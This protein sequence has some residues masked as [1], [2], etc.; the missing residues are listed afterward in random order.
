LVFSWNVSLNKSGKKN[1]FLNVQIDN[2]ISNALKLKIHIAK[3]GRSRAALSGVRLKVNSQYFGI[4][5]SDTRDQHVV[6]MQIKR[7]TQPFPYPWIDMLMVSEGAFT[8]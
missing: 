1:P 8:S 5:V 4:I 7:I 2:A 3:N 6:R